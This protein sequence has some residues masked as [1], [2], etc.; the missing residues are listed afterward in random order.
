MPPGEV[1]HLL[2]VPSQEHR[3]GL[4][5]VVEEAQPRALGE[6]GRSS[7]SGWRHS[8]TARS[9]ISRWR[10]VSRSSY[11]GPSWAFGGRCSL[12]GGWTA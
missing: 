4:A 10:V 1:P 2:C 12:Y 6:Q 11:C 7:G 3:P 8:R 5:P 9:H